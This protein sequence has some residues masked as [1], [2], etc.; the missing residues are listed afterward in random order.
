[1]GKIQNLN[2]SSNYNSTAVEIWLFS[3]GAV[4]KLF[5]YYSECVNPSIGHP[6]RMF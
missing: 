1:M 5:K 2:C 3:T 6:H 4:R